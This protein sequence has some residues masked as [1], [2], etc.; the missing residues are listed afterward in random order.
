TNKGPRGVTDN[1][2]ANHYSLLASIESAFGLGCLENS[3]AATPMTPLFEP[4]G[5]TSTPALPAPFTPAPDGTNT[6]SKTGAPVKGKP[7]SLGSA[8]EWQV[9]PSPSIGNLD[10]NLDSVSAASS[11]DAWA[12][13]NFYESSEPNVLKTL[14][15]HWDGTSWTAY[16]LPNVGPNEN[17]LFGVS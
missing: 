4:N 12:V 1:A 8:D 9:V 5:S 6:V 10:N 17:T 2:P 11:T 15:E 13:G 16:P 14:G 7:A 3:C